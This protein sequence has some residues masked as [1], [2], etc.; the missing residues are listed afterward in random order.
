MRRFRVFDIRDLRPLPIAALLA[1][2][3]AADLPAAESAGHPL[4]WGEVVCPVTGA[5]GSAEGV[6]EASPALRSAEAGE[7]RRT[8]PPTPA[9]EVWTDSARDLA[10]VYWRDVVVDSI[11]AELPLLVAEGTVGLTVR[12]SSHSDEVMLFVELIG[13]GGELLACRGCD[14]APAVGQLGVGRGTT[15]MPSTD[16]PGWELGSGMH[17]VRVR[18]YTRAGAGTA[19]G[20]DP[21]SARGSEVLV[22]V[23]AA[24]RTEAGIDVSHFLDLNFIYLPGIPLTSAIAQAM[25]EF[26][27]L[28]ALCDEAIAPLEIEIGT[29]THRDLDRPEFSTISSWEEAGEMFRT[30][31][32]VGQHR[33]VNVYCVSWFDGTLLNVAGLSGG[34]PGAAT[35][36]TR[37]SG[38]ALRSMPTFP[39]FLDAYAV[40]FAHEIG[41]Y[42]GLYHTTETNLLGEDPLSD[43]PRCNEPD[44]RACP[45]WDYEMF[46]IVNADS[47]LWSASQVAICKTHPYVRS[48][49]VVVG[50]AR[51]EIASHE[52]GS[53]SPQVFVSSNPFRETVRLQLA[54]GGAAVSAGVFDIRGRHLLTLTCRRGE[55]RWDGRDENGRDVGPGVYFVRIA[56]ES[57]SEPLHTVRLVRLR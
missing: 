28:L 39:E 4:P 54:G 6:V 53:G 22:D 3:A 17:A 32:T 29:V 26:D 33:A 27:D 20:E 16:R 7:A 57:D 24:L 37:D 14:E 8:W 41:H 25:P 23:V 31:A 10:Y 2:T 52:I 44:L 45:D 46:P 35:N 13:P 18:A 43:T 19:N 12:A 50:V 5:R 40:L 1:L 49:P 55:L 38:I 51:D 34:I 56:R 42:L 21:P 47:I 9:P 15:Q 36:G 11:S 48:V 30:S